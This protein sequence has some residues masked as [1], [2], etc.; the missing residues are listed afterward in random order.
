MIPALER[1][2]TRMS[3]GAFGLFLVV[4]PIWWFR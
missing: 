3:I 1:L 4:L 2:A